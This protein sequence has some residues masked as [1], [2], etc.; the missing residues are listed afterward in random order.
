[1]VPAG[2]SATA[3][4]GDQTAATV[5]GVVFNDSNGNGTQDDGEDG[6]SGLTVQLING[7]TRT[8]TTD[9]DGAYQFTNVTPGSYIMQETDRSGFVSTTPNSVEISVPSGGSATE[10]FG[11]QQAGTVSG[12]V[13]NDLNG[14]G[15]QDDGENGLADVS[16]TLSNGSSSTKTTD[17]KGKYNFTN[18]ALG[19]YTVSAEEL[20]GFFRTTPGA[21]AISV[22]AGVV[23][24][25][26][27]TSVISLLVR[28]AA[29]FSMT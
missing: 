21:R 23:V 10:N 8:S 25:A 28:S 4:F 9:A 7:T 5:S 22:P 19:N 11:D 20:A 2:G 6:L 27:P 12:T 3:S 1:V 29:W 24:V 14:N 16:I 26:R 13:F 15:T 17:D 18:V